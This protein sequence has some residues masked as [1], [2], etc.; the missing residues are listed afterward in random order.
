MWYTVTVKFSQIPFFKIRFNYFF[1]FSDTI[2]VSNSLDPDQTYNFIGSDLDPN[3]LHRLS[4]DDK[5][6]EHGRLSHVFVICGFFHNQ[7]FCFV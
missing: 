4:A 7:L 5:N 6:G 3:C 1:I 2:R